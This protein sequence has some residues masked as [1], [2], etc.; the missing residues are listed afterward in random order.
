MLLLTFAREESSS[1]SVGFPAGPAGDSFWIHIPAAMTAIFRSGA[2]LAAKLILGRLVG[3]IIAGIAQCRIRHESMVY[4][5]PFGRRAACAI[6]DQHHVAGLCIDCRLRHTAANA[7][8][9]PTY[10]WMTWRAQIWTNAAVL[11]P[12]RRSLA[13]NTPVVT[14][15]LIRPG[16][17]A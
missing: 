9:L 4:V 13:E 16:A 7:G 17:Q 5:T 14:E 11:A 2:N 10:A 6:S 8:L 15:N 3:S 1:R 12:V